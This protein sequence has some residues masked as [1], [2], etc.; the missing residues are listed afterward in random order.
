MEAERT[1]EPVQ[2]T[3]TLR[4]HHDLDSGETEYRTSR[5]STAETA[6]ELARRNRKQRG[7]GEMSARYKRVA[8]LLSAQ[9]QERRAQGRRPRRGGGSSVRE[10]ERGYKP[11]QIVVVQE[12]NP[13]RRIGF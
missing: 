6:A 2:R 3:S 10:K 5:P 7:D 4:Y 9:A 11:P 13:M 8:E 1:G 12:S